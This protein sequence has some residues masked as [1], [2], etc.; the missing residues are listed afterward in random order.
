MHIFPSIHPSS[1]LLYGNLWAK[2][3][4]FLNGPWWIFPSVNL[5]SWTYVHSLLPLCNMWCDGKKASFLLLLDSFPSATAPV[6]ALSPSLYLP[7]MPMSLKIPTLS[8]LA[9][10]FPAGEKQI[11]CWFW[12]KNL[13]EGTWCCSQSGLGFTCCRF[14]SLELQ[15]FCMGIKSGLKLNSTL[16]TQKSW[17]NG[18][19]KDT[20]PREWSLGCKT[21]VSEK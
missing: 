7:V 20:S 5:L 19:S 14:G 9:I 15:P 16:F 1:N 11:N 3:S 12:T 6:C 17:E 10:P 8:C 21:K 13:P 18:T 4:T 2:G